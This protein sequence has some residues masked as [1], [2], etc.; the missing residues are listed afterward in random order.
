MNVLIV[1]DDELNC[2]ALRRSL[3]AFHSIATARTV[4]D[5]LAQIRA[6]EPDAILCDVEL[7]GEMAT[8]LLRTIG[9]EH[10]RV[11]RILYSG[12][13][14][15]RLAS[16]VSDGLAERALEKPAIIEQILAAI[17]G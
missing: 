11:R 14:P 13:T 4:A 7:D 3:R 17:G 12:T 1:D 15:D 2:Q 5:A 10:P 6:A 16:F 8:E 9:R